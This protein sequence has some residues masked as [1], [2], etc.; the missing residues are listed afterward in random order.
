MILSSSSSRRTPPLQPF[1]PFADSKRHQADN[2]TGNYSEYL[3]Q[4]HFEFEYLS[5]WEDWDPEDEE[6][7]EA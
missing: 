4:D 1:N 7:L 5:R 3:P 2:N 6:N